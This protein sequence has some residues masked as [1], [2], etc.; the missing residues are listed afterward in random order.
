MDPDLDPPADEEPTEQFALQRCPHCR[1]ITAVELSLAMT[2]CVMCGER[3]EVAP[4][5]A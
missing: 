2:M 4:L 1:G 5:F 3:I